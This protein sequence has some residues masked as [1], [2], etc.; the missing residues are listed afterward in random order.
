MA[1]DYLAGVQAD[2]DLDRYVMLLA[3]ALRVLLHHFLHPQRRVAS[4][5]GVILVGER[6]AEEGHDAVSHHLVH[7]ALVDADGI[8][9]GLENGIQQLPRLLGVAACEQLHCSLEMGE[10]NRDL[11]PLALKGAL[12]G[13][14]RFDEM[15]GGI[16][17]GRRVRDDRRGAGMRA[18]NLRASSD[19]GPGRRGDGTDEPITLGRYRLDVSRARRVV[20]QGTANLA[21]RG[22]QRVVDVQH[23]IPP[24][25]ALGDLLAEHELPSPLDEEEKYLQRDSFETERPAGPP[26]LE[27]GRVELESAKSQ[28]TCGH[29]G[30]S[31]RVSIA[32]P[33]TP[34]TATAPTA[35][36][37][38]L[39]IAFASAFATMRPKGESHRRKPRCPD[40][41]GTG[42]RGGRHDQPSHGGGT[43]K[44]KRGDWEEMTRD[45][46]ICYTKAIFG[47]HKGEPT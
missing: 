46:V 20:P 40:P 19:L 14:D 26:E 44:G 13:G 36:L 9:H 7:G 8:H 23:D 29:R 27:A 24:P 42:R 6:G 1:H 16:G 25:D 12:R 5:N 47:A 4:P 2:A 41:P 35:N 31:V 10:E 28:E 34:S 17:V 39:S 38:A 30:P 21:D 37:Q 3:A 43:K 11:L 15:L 18:T 33:S 32:D 45:R 22:V